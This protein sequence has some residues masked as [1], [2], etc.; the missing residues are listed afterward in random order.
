MDYCYQQKVQ[1]HN[2][3]FALQRGVCLFPE[4][5]NRCPL[6]DSE[7]T[8]VLATELNALLVAETRSGQS[9]LKKYD[10]M[11][12]SPPKPIPETTKPS[13][14]QPVEKQKE[15][16][17]SK[18]LPKENAEGSSTLYRFDILAQM[19]NIPA[20]ITLYELLRLSKSTR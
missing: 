14:K 10:E 9:Y 5:R 2:K 15:L 8:V 12:A 20:R 13:T 11:V 16:R 17:Y 3:S 18:A 1:R 7:E 19:A 4:S 6:T